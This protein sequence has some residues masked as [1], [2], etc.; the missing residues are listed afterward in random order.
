MLKKEQKI[1]IFGANGAI[2]CALSNH[3]AS[4]G[5]EVLAVTREKHNFDHQNISNIIINYDD[6]HD[7][8][9]LCAVGP[10]DIIVTCIGALCVGE[11]MPEKSLNDI[12]EEYMQVLYRVNTIVPALIMKHVLACMPR[13]HKFIC[14]SLSARIGSISDNRLGGWYSYR[15]SKAALN[16][17]IKT[18]SIEIG[19][20]NKNAV[21]VGLHP[22]TVDSNLSKPFQNNVPDE[23]LFSPEQSA[24]Y[25]ANVISRLTK[26]HSGQVFD[27]K[28][29]V[30][31]P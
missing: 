15:A 28:A 9:A 31:D 29:E 23:K 25:L 19:R 3:Y 10:P 14:A 16:M 21:I 24:G 7:F 20:K 26:E 12:D 18:A 6:V 1:V 27:W 2:G 30:I 5:D 11:T 17:V 4:M 8:E 22:G 13:D